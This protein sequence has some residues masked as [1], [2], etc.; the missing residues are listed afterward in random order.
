MNN[1]LSSR[2][3]KKI[4]LSISA[5]VIALMIASILMWRLNS[6]NAP[7]D[8]GM[9]IDDSWGHNSHRQYIWH[10]LVALAWK[11]KIYLISLFKV[12]HME[13]Q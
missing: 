10:I 11:I 13:F 7:V 4:I 12:R 3:M 8:A 6:T 1:P 2:G 9:M 5:V